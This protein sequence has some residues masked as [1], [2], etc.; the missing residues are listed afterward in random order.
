MTA[1]P[2]PQTKYAAGGSRYR[3]ERYCKEFRHLWLPSRC[4]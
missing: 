2:I 1:I 4:K 3:A